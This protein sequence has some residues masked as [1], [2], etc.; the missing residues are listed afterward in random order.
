[1]SLKCLLLYPC[2]T[3]S[4][5]IIPV[6]AHAA[7]DKGANYLG[8]TL[9]HAPVDPETGCVLVDKVAAAIN[10]NTILIVGSTP[11]FPHGSIDDIP[12]LAKLALKHDI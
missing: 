10:S 3:H 2:L 7:F 12:A 5:R 8:I 6:S 9:I 1:M 11:S 4:N